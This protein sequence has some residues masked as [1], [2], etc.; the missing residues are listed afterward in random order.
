MCPCCCVGFLHEIEPNYCVCSHCGMDVHRNPVELRQQ[1]SSIY[2]QHPCPRAL[3]CQLIPLKGLLFSCPSCNFSM[4]L[5]QYSCLIKQT[6]VS[7]MTLELLLFW[8]ISEGALGCNITVS[9]QQMQEWMF[10]CFGYVMIQVNIVGYSGKRCCEEV[11]SNKRITKY[12]VES[13]PFSKLPR[14]LFLLYAPLKVLFQVVCAPRIDSRS[15]S[16]SF[17]SLSRHQN[18]IS[19]LYRIHQVFQH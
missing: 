6:S 10:V 5:G 16:F 13:N 9:H 14:K 8:V 4:F 18:Q 17:S 12:L 19:T 1:F 7:L 2:Q 11:E 3:H 15:F